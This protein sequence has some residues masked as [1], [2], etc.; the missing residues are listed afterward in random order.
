MALCGVDWTVVNE[1][2]CWNVYCEVTVILPVCLCVRSIL[3]NIEMSNSVRWVHLNMVEMSCWDELPYDQ[4]PHGDQENRIFLDWFWLH[5]PHATFDKLFLFRL[6]C[7]SPTW[8]QTNWVDSLDRTN[9]LVAG[10]EF[11]LI[12]RKKSTMWR[13]FKSRFV[14]FEEGQQGQVY[15]YIQSPFDKRFRDKCGRAAINDIPAS[16]LKRRG[17]DVSA[18]WIL[19]L[20]SPDLDR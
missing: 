3:Y 17:G 7:I 20:E 15:F 16:S 2:L 10:R 1:M 13:C 12:T 6:D 11:P 19:D 18:V 4:W 9:I 5:S 14:I 8:T